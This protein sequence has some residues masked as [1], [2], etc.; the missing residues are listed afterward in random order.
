M[1][2]NGAKS[3]LG[4]VMK[5]QQSKYIPSTFSTTSLSDTAYAYVPTACASN[6]S[7][8]Q[9]HVA[10]HGCEQTIAQIGEDFITETGYTDWAATT[11]NVI[12]LFPQAVTTMLSNPEGC[13]DWWAT[14]TRILPTRRASR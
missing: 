3:S 9:V 6:T 10:L 8:C 2:G 12:V 13:F 14:P 1:G 7:V 11:G 4:S 5:I